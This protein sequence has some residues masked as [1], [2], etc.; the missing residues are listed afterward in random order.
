MDLV[1]GSPDWAVFLQSAVITVLIGASMAIASANGV[2]K[3]CRSNRR[4]S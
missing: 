4:L 2:G 3:G 1:F